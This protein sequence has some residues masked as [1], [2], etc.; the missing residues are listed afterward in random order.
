MI[1]SAPGL[2]VYYLLKMAAGGMSDDRGP[3]RPRRKVRRD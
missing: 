1:A 2:G 3:K